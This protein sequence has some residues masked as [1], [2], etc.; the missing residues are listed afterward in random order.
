MLLLPDI[1]V[2]GFAYVGVHLNSGGCIHALK[3]LIRTDY[4]KFCKQFKVLR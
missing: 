3:E 1:H 2:P 4:G